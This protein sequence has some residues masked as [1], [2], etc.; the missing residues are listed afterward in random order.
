MVEVHYLKKQKNKV[1]FMLEVKNMEGKMK[2]FGDK[3]KECL[4]IS[5]TI[6]LLHNLIKLIECEVLINSLSAKHHT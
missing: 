6:N 4:A 1:D 5:D 2:S 3:I